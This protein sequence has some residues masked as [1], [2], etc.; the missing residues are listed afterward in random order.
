MSAFKSIGTLLQSS[1][2]TSAIV[3]MTSSGTANSFLSSYSFTRT[4]NANQIT[5]SCMYKVLK[6][7][8]EY[9]CNEADTIAGTILPFD[10]W[11][12]KCLRESPQFHFGHLVLSMELTILPF[13]RAS[14]EAN[15]TLYYQSL[16]VLIPICQQQYKL[17]MVPACSSL[18]HANL[19][20]KTSRR[21]FRSSNLVSLLSSNPVAHPLP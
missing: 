15:F 10:D 21:F 8:Y 11:C 3:A 1:D 7:A 4:R 12:K 13:V 17:C 9:D 6:D 14:R 16:C 2:W 19:R 20:T 5:A 18:R